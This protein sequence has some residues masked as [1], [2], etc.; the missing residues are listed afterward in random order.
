MG[1]GRSAHGSGEG[2]GDS[3]QCGDCPA[4]W[5]RSASRLHG[6]CVL[7]G[8]K[9][10]GGNDGG[11]EREASSSR[12][13]SR[14]STSSRIQWASVTFGPWCGIVCHHISFSSSWCVVS[15]EAPCRREGGDDSRVVIDRPLFCGS[16]FSSCG[17]SVPCVRSEK[18]GEEGEGRP[19]PSGVTSTTFSASIDTA[20][21]RR[22][23]LLAVI[24]GDG[25][26]GG[27]CSRN[28]WLRPTEEEGKVP[29]GEKDGSRAS[30]DPWSASPASRDTVEAGRSAGE[31]WVGCVVASSR[32]GAE[33]D[34]EEEMG[35]RPRKARGWEK[36]DV[37]SRAAEEGESKGGGRGRKG[38]PESAGS[39]GVGCVEEGTGRSTADDSG[40]AA[41]RSTSDPPTEKG[42]GGRG[43]TVE[44]SGSGEAEGEESSE[45]DSM[46]VQE[47]KRGESGEGE[48]KRNGAEGDG[49]GEHED[50]NGEEAEEDGEGGK[51]MGVGERGGDDF[52][53]FHGEREECAVSCGSIRA[54][55]EENSTPSPSLFASSFASAVP[56]HA[57]RTLLVRSS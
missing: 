38:T 17:S 23:R 53:A 12:S 6:P 41:M 28:D 36:G 49:E 22:R 30:D 55:G 16:S 9:Q 44:A 51:K 48:E 14:S 39:V 21:A 19:S 34:G 27:F 3:D 10:H 20:L 57:C 8:P 32:G 52:I 50:G 33:S 42:G 35:G 15:R 54:K 29:C 45:G 13:R 31:K 46:E 43:S 7:G 1:V 2:E 56:R 4:T 25:R 18:E 24:A 47:E 37:S 26:S 5:S 40:P 11:G